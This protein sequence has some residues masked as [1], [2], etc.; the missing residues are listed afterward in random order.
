[1]FHERRFKGGEKA[2]DESRETWCSRLTG[3]LSCFLHGHHFNVGCQAGFWVLSLGVSP[4]WELSRREPGG[5]RGGRGG[6]GSRGER[7]Q[8]PRKDPQPHSSNRDNIHPTAISHQHFSFIHDTAIIHIRESHHLDKRSIK[9]ASP[10]KGKSPSLPPSLHLP[11]ENQNLAGPEKGYQDYRFA[12]EMEVWRMGRG[13]NSEV[14]GV[15]GTRLV[16]TLIRV[17]RWVISM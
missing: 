12:C 8:P 17:G 5:G 14:T 15:W 4:C 6:R 3:F 13:G 11:A 7:L 16:W 1:M 9:A 10:S 2:S